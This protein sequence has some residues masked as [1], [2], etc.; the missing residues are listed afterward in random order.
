MGDS[1]HLCS[2]L[3]NYIQ[4]QACTFTCHTCDENQINTNECTMEHC[5]KHN[6]QEGKMW[7]RRDTENIRTSLQKTLS[8]PKPCGKTCNYLMRQRLNCLALN[9]KGIFCTKP[10]QE[11][12]TSGETW[13]RQHDAL[14]LLPSDVQGA[15]AETNGKNE[16]LPISRQFLPQNLLSSLKRLN[17]KK[18]FTQQ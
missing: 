10:L 15:L 13:W 12:H 5:L 2:E 18:N 11:C 3:N 4:N 16:Q 14:R 7:H 6:Q 1:A 8:H 9:L 17:L